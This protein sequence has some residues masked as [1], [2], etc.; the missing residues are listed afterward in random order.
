MA[1]SEHMSKQCPANVTGLRMG[2]DDTNDKH[3][4]RDPI[5]IFKEIHDTTVPIYETPKESPSSRDLLETTDDKPLVGEK[6][7]EQQIKG[8]E[9]EQE[10]GNDINQTQTRKQT[11]EDA[12]EEDKEDKEEEAKATQDEE[13]DAGETQR[14]SYYQAFSTPASST[15][16]QSSS[17]RSRNNPPTNYTTTIPI[18][19]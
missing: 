13:L 8:K 9:I 6:A 17:S 15:S 5:P 18:T 10:E 3:P 14:E 1:G 16:S 12:K 11:R 4:T 7:T 2:P 19:N